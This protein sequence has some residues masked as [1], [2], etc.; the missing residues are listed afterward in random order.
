MSLTREDK[1]W[2]CE[3]AA[4]ILHYTILILSDRR[5]LLNWMSGVRQASKKAFAELENM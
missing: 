1:V 3:L 4:T 5:Q 2:L